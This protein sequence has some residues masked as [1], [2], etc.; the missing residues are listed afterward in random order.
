[1]KRVPFDESVLKLRD[2]YL[3][4]GILGPK[5]AED[6]GHVAAATV[7]GADLIVSWNFKQIV[8]F[9]KIRLCNAV[10]A[11]HGFAALDIRSPLEVIEYED[12]DE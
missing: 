9:G 7:G 4:N 10:N 6:A 8:H 5:W 1:M 11:L 2:A 3:E 12:Q